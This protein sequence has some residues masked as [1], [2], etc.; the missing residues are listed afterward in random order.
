LVD[1]D[2]PFGALIGRFGV[3][4]NARVDRWHRLRL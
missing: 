2:A 1:D 3:A 4:G